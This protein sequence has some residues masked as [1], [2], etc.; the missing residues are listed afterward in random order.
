MKP[1]SAY[2][3]V[4]EDLMEYTDYTSS[5][6]IKTQSD[7]RDFFNQVIEDAHSKNRK[8]SRSAKLFNRVADVLNIAEKEERVI[9]RKLYDA[10]KSKKVFKSLKMAKASDMAVIVDKQLIY[11]SMVVINK[12][13]IIRWRDSKGR[14]TK[15]PKEV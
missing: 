6:Q 14:F 2:E 15:T 13:Q 8:F 4:F 3:D 1:L 11:K 10:V 5:K 9:R 7:L 12:K